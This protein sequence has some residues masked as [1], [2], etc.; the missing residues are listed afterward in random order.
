MT[1][2]RAF[3]LLFTISSLLF[4][5]NNNS[6][7]NDS[8]MKM[9]VEEN[10]E[11]KESPVHLINKEEIKEFCSIVGNTAIDSILLDSCALIIHDQIYNPAEFDSVHSAYKLWGA[12]NLKNPQPV[13][14]NFNAYEG[15]SLKWQL[16]CID[17][18]LY[19][20][21]LVGVVDG[22]GGVVTTLETSKHN[23]SIKWPASLH[24]DFNESMLEISKGLWHEEKILIL[25]D[26]TVFVIEKSKAQRFIELA[27]AI[28]YQDIIVFD[29]KFEESE[30]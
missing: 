12:P 23:S 7:L 30:T 25:A 18:N 16:V 24:E 22:I 8:E 20:F 19:Q 9:G 17:A 2:S 6:E 3:L 26:I 4:S 21:Q 10:A 28:G 11:S 14:D 13:L 27:S 15:D 29:E 5:C 1:Q